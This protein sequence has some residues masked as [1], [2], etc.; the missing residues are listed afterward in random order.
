[1]SLG[2]GG[3]TLRGNFDRFL[4][5]VVCS[6][7]FGIVPMVLFGNPW[8][9][10]VALTAFVFVVWHRPDIAWALRQRKGALGEEAVARI[11]DRLEPR[12]FHTIHDLDV[13]RGNVDHV[14]VGPTGVFAIET[15]ARR[16]RFYLRKGGRLMVSGHDGG[17]IT[18]QAIGEAREIRRRLTDAGTPVWVE[19]VV[20]LTATTLPKGPINLSNVSVI[21]IADLEAFITDRPPRLSPVTVARAVGAIYRNGGGI[22]ARPIDGT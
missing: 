5:A 11:L 4:L 16:G 2:K 3:G 6:L 14:V 12:G 9:W 21:E 7:P 18:R 20:A 13:G 15:K 17:A 10:G 8:Y 1:M 19:S 22:T